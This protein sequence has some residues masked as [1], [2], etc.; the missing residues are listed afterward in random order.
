MRD[1]KVRINATA[2]REGLRTAMRFGTA[3]DPE[4]RPKF[5]VPDAIVSDPVDSSDPDGTPFYWESPVQPREGDYVE[6]V[7][8]ALEYA[9]RPGVNLDWTQV[10]PARIVV[11]LLDEEEKI[12]RGFTHV[13]IGGDRYNYRNQ[14]APL[15]L[16]EIGVHQF[17]VVA[18]DNS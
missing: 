1:P 5:F 14:L 15:G 7:T 17:M 12:V 6:D 9:D 8:C 18:E 13:L 10:L 2:V 4:L 11:T 3:P 16:G